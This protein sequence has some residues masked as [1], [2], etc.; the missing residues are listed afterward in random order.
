MDFFLKLT[1]I[2][3]ESILFFMIGLRLALF[4]KIDLNLFKLILIFIVVW[5][6]LLF[7]FIHQPIQDRLYISV[8]WTS[9]IGVG[10]QFGKKIMKN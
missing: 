2:S 7:I 9:V 6:P 4:R 3:Y 1:L 10:F 5:I 8:I